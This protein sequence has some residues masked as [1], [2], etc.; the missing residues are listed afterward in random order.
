MNSSRVNRKAGSYSRYP[1]SG[2][3]Y[4]RSHRSLYYYHRHHYPSSRIF[5]WIS[6]PDCCRPIC[7]T[8]GPHYTFGSFW[9]YHHRRF[10]FVSLGGYWPR[11][12]YRRYYWYGCHPYRWYGHY[13]PGYVIGGD[14]Y[15]YYYYNDAPKG[16][17]LEEANR[18]FEEAPRAEPSQETQTDRL[19]DRAV[20]DFEGEDYAGAAAKFG[21]AQDREPGDVVLPFAYVQALFAGGEYSAAAAALREALAKASPEEEGVFFPRGLYPQD[22]IL[23]DHIEQLTRTSQLNPSDTDLRLLLGYQLLGM[24]KLDEAGGHLQSAGADDKNRQSATVLLGMLEKLKKADGKNTDSNKQQ[25]GSPKANDAG[26]IK[27]GTAKAPPTRKRQD[28]DMV[29]LAMA[30]DNWLAR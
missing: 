22:S 11:Y 6:W 17:A 29:A 3:H 25:L 27:S 8:W 7:Y 4:S 24:G 5:Y 10:V 1:Y 26:Q 30:A 2:E 19:F 18:E 9:P 12:T 13:P 23:Q 21:E 16:E 20:K 15:N 14:T 28:V